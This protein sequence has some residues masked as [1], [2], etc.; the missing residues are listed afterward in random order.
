MSV[1]SRKIF[2]DKDQEMILQLHDQHRTQHD[3]AR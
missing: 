1:A 3:L 2:D